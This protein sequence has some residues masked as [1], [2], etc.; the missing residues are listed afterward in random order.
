MR[1]GHC[2]QASKHVR[3]CVGEGGEG[4][5]LFCA[6]DEAAIDTDAIEGRIDNNRR[7]DMAP[8]RISSRA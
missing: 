2:V 1:G 7:E 3:A 6:S 4:G 5:M 8:L